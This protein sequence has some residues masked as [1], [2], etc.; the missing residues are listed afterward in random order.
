MKNYTIPFISS[1]LLSFIPS[2]AYA[3]PCI[4]TYE[5]YR[6]YLIESGYKPIKCK[7]N[8][9]KKWNE[10]CNETK[11]LQTG[12]TKWTDKDNK[13]LFTL[14]VPVT[15]YKGYCVLPNAEYTDFDQ[16]KKDDV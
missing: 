7:V 12:Y 14:P 16:Q 9:N 6:S 15:Y 11:E 10:L 1:V 5:N 2:L 8:P 4:D 13:Y 3:L